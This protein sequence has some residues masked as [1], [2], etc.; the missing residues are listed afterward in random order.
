[1]SASIQQSVVRWRKGSIVLIQ[2][3][4]FFFLN[5]VQKVQRVPG[6]EIGPAPMGDGDPNETLLS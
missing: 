4:V 5:G 6:M 3:V 1:M 2:R